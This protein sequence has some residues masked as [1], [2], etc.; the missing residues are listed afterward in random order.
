[1]TQKVTTSTIGKLLLCAVVFVVVELRVACAQLQ[2]T[3]VMHSP[4]GNDSLWEWV[5]IRN[6]S[7]SAI[8]LDGWVFDDDDDGPINAMVGANIRAANGNTIVPAGGVAVLYPAA[9]LDFTPSRFTAAWGSGIN[10]IP[11]TNFTAITATDAIG[12]WPSYDA[13]LADTI[14]DVST[15]PRRTFA[16]AVAVLDYS[17]GFPTP[18]NGR[19]IAWK[20]A[21]SV[22]GGEN[23]VVSTA[24]TNGTLGP[25]QEVVSVETTFPSAPVNNVADLANPG[26]KPSGAAAAGLLI[27]EIMFAPATPSAQGWSATH[28]EWIEVLNNTAA[29]IDF[30]AKHHTFDDHTGTTAMPNVTSGSIGVGQVGVLFNAAQLTVDQMAT[31]WGPGN[32]IPVTAWPQLNNSGGDTIAIWNDHAAYSNEDIDE[33]DHRATE[34]AIAAVTYN[35]VAGQ[36]LGWPTLLAGRSIYM[37]DLTANPNLG[38]S[39]TRTGTAAD[40][41]GSYNAMPLVLEAVV[42]HPGGDIGSPGTVPAVVPVGLTGDYNND[43]RVDAADYT[44]WRNNLGG[45]GTTLQNRDSANSGAV[46]I[47][48]YN[49]W[50]ARYGN[51]LFGSGGLAGSLP[52]PEP[53][54]AAMFAIAAAIVARARR[55]NR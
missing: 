51:S 36:G 47:G 44:V 19:S 38:P 54:S 41:I 21:G 45:A 40:T 31:I 12:L 27:T 35:T 43:G 13:Y 14:P 18:G 16:S 7:A 37:K 4:R 48:D 3:E 53:T 39:W 55:R 29:T 32:Y 11:V 5:E 23:W 9:Q 8:N 50:K 52:V 10:L 33:E 24:G 17:T 30:A 2:F 26:I 46:G 28:F 6:P 25:F 42:D 34:S 15:S 1:M 49:S 20:G 22:T